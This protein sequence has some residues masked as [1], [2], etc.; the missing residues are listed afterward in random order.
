M[1]YSL[2]CKGSLWIFMIHCVNQCFCGRTQFTIKSVGKI[3][4]YAIYRYPFISGPAKCGPFSGP[5]PQPW[6]DATSSHVHLPPTAACSSRC[7][8]SHHGSVESGG[9]DAS[10]GPKG[11]RGWRRQQQCDRR[12][13]DEGRELGRRVFFVGRVFWLDGG[14][15]F[16]SF[17]EFSPQGSWGND[18]IWLIFFGWV[19]STTT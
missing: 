12:E 2:L 1:I 17:L 15:F 8:E 11:G 10:E 13:D 16:L 7:W 18:P 4:P 9:T 3:L 19:G 6:C 14:N 5:L